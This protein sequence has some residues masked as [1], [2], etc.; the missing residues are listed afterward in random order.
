[1]SCREVEANGDIRQL[2]PQRGRPFTNA[3]SHTGHRPAPMALAMS[4]TRRR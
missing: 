1:M 2:G 3:T 4:G